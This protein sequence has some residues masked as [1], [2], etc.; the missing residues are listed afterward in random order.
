MLVELG[1]DSVKPDNAPTRNMTKLTVAGAISAGKDAGSRPT[2]RLFVT[3]AVWNEAARLTLGDTWV[4]GP[5]LQQ[6]YGD[7]KS[8]TSV[9]IQAE[10]W[11]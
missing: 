2:L 10:A 11:W 3:H 5:R 7:Q 6:V 1:T 8:G 4:N 9:G